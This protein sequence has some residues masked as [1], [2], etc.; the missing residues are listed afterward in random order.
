MIWKLSG[1]WLFIAGAVVTMLSYILGYFIDKIMNSDGFGPFGNM[2]V[3]SG[4]SFS[5]VYAY[6]WFGYRVDD[7][8]EGVAVGLAGAFVLLASAAIG[9]SLLMRS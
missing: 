8:R 3:I 5:G 1:E 6:N 2:V 4:G 7:L 9:R